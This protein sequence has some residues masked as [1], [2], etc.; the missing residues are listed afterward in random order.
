MDIFLLL[1]LKIVSELNLNSQNK[2]DLV[3]LDKI[4]IYIYMNI[5]LFTNH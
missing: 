5:F 4:S 1:H 2:C 3:T